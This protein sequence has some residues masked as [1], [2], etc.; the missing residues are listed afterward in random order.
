MKK[1]FS[2]LLKILLTTLSVL[3]LV[4]TFP[5]KIAA[6]DE[7]GTDS[8]AEQ[9][10]ILE[11]EEDAADDEQKPEI[12]VKDSESSEVSNQ[13]DVAQNAY[14]LSNTQNTNTD[15]ESDIKGGANAIQVS[16]WDELYEAC[17]NA[18]DN[19]P[20]TI[21]LSEDIT[22]P[23]DSDNDRIEINNKK[24]I[25][26]D[27]ND[28]TLHA[29]R[30][31]AGKYYHVLD[32]HEGGNLTVLDSGFSGTIKGGYA[33]YGGGIY[34]SEGGTCTIE[35][36]TI[37]SN[38]ANEKGGGIYT[39]GTLIMTGGKISSNCAS[40]Q[41]GGGIYCTGSGMIQLKHVFIRE[42]DAN[43]YG[44]GI[45]IVLGNDDSYIQECYFEKNGINYFKARGGGIY[46]DAVDANKTLKITDSL[47]D[48][49]WGLRYG[50][51]IYLK[52]GTIQ[53]TGGRITSNGVTR[54][55]GDKLY[56]AGVYVDTDQTR[57]DADSVTIDANRFTIS[58]KGAGIYNNKGTVALTNCTL[59]DN[60]A[61]EEGGGIY[62]A[63][64]GWL[65]LTET[66]ITN[67]SAAVG[68]GVYFEKVESSD[69]EQY[70]A[71]M[72]AMGNTVISDNAGSDVYLPGKMVLVISKN[73][74]LGSEA[75]I[76]I[77][78]PAGPGT[79]TMDFERYMP[80]GSM[81]DTYFFSND[82]YMVTKHEGEGYLARKASRDFVPID[83]QIRSTNQLIPN[84]W[85]AGI[86]GERYLYEI[87]TPFTHD[88]GM[89]KYTAPWDSSI[90]AALGFHE[91]A[92]TQYV[93][94]K[95]Q[96]EDGVRVLDLRLNPVYWGKDGDWR[97]GTMEMDDGENL[98][99]CHGKNSGGGV[100][101]TEDEDGNRLSFQKVLDWA[102]EF[103]A[104]NPTE[105]VILILDAE[106]TDA[107]AKK[108]YREL[109]FQRIADHLEKLAAK[110]N[111]SNGK[112]YIYTEPGKTFRDKYTH[113]PQLKDCRGQIVLKVCE[114]EDFDY[115]GG[116]ISYDMSPVTDIAPEKGGGNCVI[117][118][119]KIEN[120]KPYFAQCEAVQIP[121]NVQTHLTTFH[122]ADSNSKANAVTDFI[123]DFGRKIIGETVMQPLA[124]ANDVHKNVFQVEKYFEGD[125]IGNY[126]GFFKM[127]GAV[128]SENTAIWKTN[129]P[130][131]LD[132]VTLSV[133]PG[134]GGEAYLP[135]QFKLLRYTEIDIPGCIYDNPNENGG[136][137]Q[138]WEAYDTS[139]NKIGEFYEGDE[140]TV[141]GDITFRAIWSDSPRTTIRIEWKDADNK[142]NL[143]PET[144]SLR[145]N[146]DRIITVT[147]EKN[148][149]TSYVGD[150][151]SV[152]PEW[153]RI[154][155]GT[156]T[157]EVSGKVRD[158]FVVTLIHSP[159]STMNVSA[160]IVWQDEEDIDRLRPESITLH[161][162][163]NG[164]EIDSAD[165]TQSDGWAYAF[166]EYPVYVD[167]E[168]AE[169]VITEDDINDYSVVRGWNEDHT[170][171]GSNITNIHI[172][173][174][175][176]FN[177]Y[178]TWNDSDDEMGERPD[179][180]RVYL[181]ADGEEIASE[182]VSEI[183]WGEDDH[184]GI[185][186][187][188]FKVYKS[189][190]EN[191]E[192][193]TVK[194]EEI[195]RYYMEIKESDTYTRQIIGED[196]EIIEETVHV[197]PPYYEIIYTY[198]SQLSNGKVERVEP[199]C[200]ED[201]NIEYW[202]RDSAN[203]D[204]EMIR[205]YYADMKGEEEISYE[206]TI[207]PALGHDWT[208]PIYEW[209]KLTV[210][211]K[212]ECGRDHS[213]D[214]T[215]TADIIV[216][217]TKQATPAEKGVKISTATFKNPAF[218]KQTKT[219]EFE[220]EGY[221]VSFNTNG[222]QPASIKAQT[223]TMD[224]QMK[225]TK[226]DDP[227]KGTYDFEG[228][229][230]DDGTFSTEWNFNDE[231]TGNTKL[232]ARY[233]FT[234]AFLDADKVIASVTVY[235]DKDGKLDEPGIKPTKEG[236]TFDYWAKPDTKPFDFDKEEAYPGLNLRANYFRYAYEG[237]RNTWM[238]GNVGTSNF[239]FVRWQYQ[240]KDYESD[241][242]LKADFETNEKKAYVDG[243]LLS[244]DVYTYENGS[245]IVKLKDSYLNT[246]SVG[247]HTLK[248]EFTDG[249]AETVF[250]VIKKTE[251]VTPSYT[252]P[253]TGDR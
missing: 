133:D 72:R 52:E 8:E 51:G 195:L 15:N 208:E 70:P 197:D 67:N 86:S 171:Y 127:D 247:D 147:N 32:V 56:G 89:W 233:G 239:R 34:I 22:R 194:G 98:W 237:S 139:G 84:N 38:Y 167:G 199:T 131:D 227:R 77:A 158:G 152:V 27:L 126:Y 49:N 183:V 69:P 180:V 179:S 121:K 209:S 185:W 169:Y 103:L 23:S 214:Q 135:Q 28:K 20:T 124:I 111:P 42:N 78:H 35:G 187:W 246:L 113:W 11:Q 176:T 175:I 226:P 114:P 217:V 198:D 253:K 154:T 168:E 241:K 145:T 130:K 177:G 119:E 30:T 213:H 165:V 156:Y 16:S 110:K 142:D 148:W 47:F 83:S 245:L 204:G 57:F 222:G 202:Y 162:S 178:I 200:T 120:L 182:E 203:E 18:P 33:N 228:W 128:R 117:A 159:E 102:E 184:T 151:E 219:E 44:S 101:Y 216:E 212:R 94:I 81:P 122:H 123:V 220:F 85:M 1:K 7:S 248:V 140:Y 137:F 92:H 116:F 251:P 13:E 9:Q 82:G 87:N 132:Y 181:L 149:K 90:G 157:Y 160:K 190:I 80:E 76:G 196:G 230:I 64:A 37:S 39:E 235:E 63:K 224:T 29:N 138:Y 54:A 143:R 125:A 6:D 58:G 161:L 250:T 88:S 45:M 104:A 74:P 36:G 53:M 50:G 109:T 249:E 59:T 5:V 112:S 31:S 66:K 163:R 61:G 106:I 68:G 96:L 4:T 236:Y 141:T 211:A 46:V 19:V 3:L 24:V 206:E 43:D 79:F 215:E 232:I 188:S 107:N 146:S 193:I 48:N 189:Q 153:E 41:D 201:G 155:D 242:D 91:Y 60:K 105:T 234:V 240:V 40:S 129:F 17:Q 25:V 166:G 225:L 73:N 75:R 218:K 223:V 186:Q 170:V 164:Q 95:Q 14:V 210:T 244:E 71:A 252:P 231:V 174:T 118:S 243:T 2:L 192:E 238:L 10:E 191:S 172:P 21:V 26:L 150:I 100:Y 221:E 93:S 115:I 65:T 134:T 55:D 12:I 173:Q 62:E 97:H 207:L 229:Y 144:L 136:E 99:L 205:S 108:G